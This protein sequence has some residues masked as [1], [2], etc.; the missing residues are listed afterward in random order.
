MAGATRPDLVVLVASTP[1][2][3]DGLTEDLTRL[4]GVAP[5]AIAGAGATGAIAD[6]VGAHLLTD[7][8]VTAAERMPSPGSHRALR[9]RQHPGTATQD[10]DRG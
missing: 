3:F 6:A 4:A 9:R 8:P 5:L 7:D 2:R 10:D 1:Q